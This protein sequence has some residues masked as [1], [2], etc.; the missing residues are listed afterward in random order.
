[1]K[2]LLVQS[3]TKDLQPV[4]PV[5]LARL[6]GV[7]HRDH[8]LMV[9]DPN[10]EP[11][12]K[13]ELKDRLIRFQ[14][15]LVGISLRNVD[16]VDYLA[17][18]NFYPDFADTVKQIRLLRPDARIVVGG[19][20]FSLFAEEIMQDQPDIDVGVFLEAEDSFPELLRHIDEP[21][22]VKGIYYRRNGSPM[23]TG[24]RPP[25][26]FARLPLPAYG[27]FDLPR[28]VSRTI[29]IGVESKR[30]C[31][32]RCGYCPYPFLNGRRVRLKPPETVVDEIEWLVSKYG[33]DHFAF[34]DSIF[35]V[36]LEHSLDVCNEILSRNLKIRWSSWTNEKFFSEEYAR[37]AMKSGCVAFPFSTDALTDTSLTLLRKNFTHADIVNTVEIAC[38]ISGIHV[39]FNFFLNPP[40]S[41]PATFLETLWFII[42]AK[43]V[44]GKK[45]RRIF[46]FNRIRIEPH[47]AM[48]ERALA[49]GLVQPGESLLKPVYYTHPSTRW[50]ESAYDFLMFPFVLMVRVRRAIRNKWKKK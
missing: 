31:G 16:S 30:G 45:M 25:P 34:V 5:G 6:A 32:L 50:I 23:F 43:I 42:R 14:P 28:Y 18:D 17:R 44:L 49:E 37:L 12:W 33:I 48:H 21:E 13:L 47:T 3:Y 19:S 35:N 20:G 22:R 39:G 29:G 40:G 2:I 24:N 4:F 27:L 9:F 11:R 10:M 46:L 36:P 15:D 7:I 26:D 8:D 41:T 38:K 1:M